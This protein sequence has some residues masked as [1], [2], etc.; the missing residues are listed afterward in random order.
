MYDLFVKSR[1]LAILQTRQT[2]GRYRVGKAL[3]GLVVTVSLT[4]RP[5]L[6]LLY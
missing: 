3:T 1:L 5:Y 6:G 2:V 4:T